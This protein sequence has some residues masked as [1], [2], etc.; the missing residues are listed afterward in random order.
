MIRP[1]AGDK[2][3]S[4]SA[5]LHAAHAESFCDAFAKAQAIRLD[6]IRRESRGAADE[7]RRISH[8]FVVRP[9][10]EALTVLIRRLKVVGQPDGAISVK[11]EH[12]DEGIGRIALMRSVGTS[13]PDFFHGIVGQLANVSPNSKNGVDEQWLNFMLSMVRSV[14][15]KDGTEAMIATQLAALHALALTAA[16]R[17]A[18][19]ATMAQQ[20]SAER[21]L[22]KLSR[23]F[24]ALVT[25][26]KSWRSKGEQ[27]VLVQHVTVDGGSQA[28]VGNVHTGSNALPGVAEINDG[29]PH[30][31]QIAYALEP[32]LFSPDA[33]RDA[34][35]VAS[36]AE[37]A[38]PDARR[39]VARRPSGK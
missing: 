8:P 30:A 29:Q 28:I 24:A 19:A 34:L 10:A 36:D 21:A 22:N 26:L 14:E 7:R 5:S 39:K 35:S 27:R 32:A 11:P 25:T 13:D 31:K 33:P 38:L 15:P 16:R 37:W 2:S 6:R 3:L 1:Q 9:D 18:Q 20:D 23:S 17:L 12:P 4:R